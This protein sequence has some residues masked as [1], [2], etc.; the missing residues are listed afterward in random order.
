[1]PWASLTGQGISHHLTVWAGKDLAA[2]SCQEQGGG[3]P[4]S[5]AFSE[6][7][8]SSFLSVELLQA[9]MVPSLYKTF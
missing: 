3:D 5:L 6:A 9:A 8:G 1:M 2:G 4:E 7:H